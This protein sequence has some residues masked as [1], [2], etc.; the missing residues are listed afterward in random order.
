MSVQELPLVL[1][2]PDRN[3]TS[4]HKQSLP[5]QLQKI[6]ARWGSYAFSPPICVSFKTLFFQKEMNPIQKHLFILRSAKQINSLFFIQRAIICFSQTQ[7]QVN[8]LGYHPP[9]Q[10]FYICKPPPP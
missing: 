6:E 5:Y 3:D 2:K 10:L 7:K 9:L 1:H 4:T 8:F